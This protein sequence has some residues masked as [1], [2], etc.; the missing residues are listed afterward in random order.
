MNGRIFQVT[1]SGEIVW[2]YVNPF[3]KESTLSGT[4]TINTN[5]VFRAQPVPYD[6]VPE[7]TP[8]SEKGLQPIDISKFRVPQTKNN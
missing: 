4:Q 1:P 6:W 7:G 5:W 2:E 8:H 3:F